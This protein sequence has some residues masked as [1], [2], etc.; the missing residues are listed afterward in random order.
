M[1]QTRTPLA[2]VT[3]GAITKINETG[4]AAM[5]VTYTAARSARL[6]SVSVKLGAI[7]TTGEALTI[8]LDAVAGAAYDVLLY[9]LDPAALS[10]TSLIVTEEDYGDVW[11]IPGDKIV[12]AYT[13]TDA[14]TYGVEIVAM[15]AS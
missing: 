15:E 7:P 6:I 14:A 4:D 3:A 13:N 5:S 1:P 11:L 2:G 10:L 12:I 8:T 9:S